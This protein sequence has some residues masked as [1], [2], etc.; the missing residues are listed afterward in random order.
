VFIVRLL[1]PRTLDRH[2]VSSVRYCNQRRLATQ[3]SE[4][5]LPVSSCLSLVMTRVNERVQKVAALFTAS[6]RR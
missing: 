1:E 5:L 3:K 2:V 4:V 6:G